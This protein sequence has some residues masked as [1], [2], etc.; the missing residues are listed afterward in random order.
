VPLIFGIPLK[1]EKEVLG[2]HSMQNDRDPEKPQ[3]RADH[4]QNKG[5]PYIDPLTPAT[6]LHG[7]GVDQGRCKAREENQMTN[8]LSFSSN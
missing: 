6:G 7:P 3:K 4:N 1:T 5:K 2:L 8:G